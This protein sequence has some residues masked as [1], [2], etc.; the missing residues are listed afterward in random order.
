MN[1]CR[2]RLTPVS[3]SF[4]YCVPKK[5]FVLQFLSSRH[6]PQC[7]RIRC[8]V[9][10]NQISNSLSFLFFV[11]LLFRKAS[12]AHLHHR[13]YLNQSVSIYVYFSTIQTYN[14]S[15]ARARHL[16][17]R[18]STV[19]KNLFIFFFFLIFFRLLLYVSMRVFVLSSFFRRLRL[20]LNEQ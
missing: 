18:L 19:M 15:D 7:G 5:F 6:I 3:T 13:R 9:E 4:G 1:A 12:D 16:I 2:A 14:F 17:P 11:F 10:K 20:H 8:R